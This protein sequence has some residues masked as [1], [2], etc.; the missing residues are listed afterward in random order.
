MESNVRKLKSSLH[1]AVGRTAIGWIS[2][3]IPGCDI[4]I[5]YKGNNTGPCPAKSIVPMTSDELTSAVSTK[6]EILISFLNDDVESPVIVGIVQDVPDFRTSC[7][8][9]QGEYRKRVRLTSPSTEN[10]LCC[11]GKRRWSSDAA[12]PRLCWIV[13]VIYP[14]K[15]PRF[16]RSQS[17]RIESPAV[18]SEST[19]TELS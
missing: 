14:S 5:D 8:R 10:G 15:G 11:R 9:K 12:R 16:I 3:W 2:S 7:S 19:N 1:S 13:M 6:R 4:L 17:D 18:A